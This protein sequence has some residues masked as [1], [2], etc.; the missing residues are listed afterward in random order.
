MVL[1]RYEQAN[2]YI[3]CLIPE[4]NFTVWHKWFHWSA[5]LHSTQTLSLLDVCVHVVTNKTLKHSRWQELRAIWLVF[6]A[7][8]Y[9]MVTLHNDMISGLFPTLQG[10]YC[11]ILLH[12][13]H[14]YTDLPF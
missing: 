7:L 10:Y 12:N 3:K 11:R 2:T 14:F 5:L 6:N 8:L 4:N 9:F 1:N 13:L